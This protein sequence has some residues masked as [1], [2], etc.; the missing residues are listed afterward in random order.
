ML[1]AIDTATEVA[2]LALAKDGQILAEMTW[3]TRQNHTVQ[4]LPNLENL[5]KLTGTTP[6][7]LTAVIVGLG[8]GSFNGLRVGV[9]AAKGLAF[10]LNIPI[11]GINSLEVSA[12]PYAATGLPVC[13]VIN[14]GRSEVATA[15]YQSVHG[16]WQRTAPDQIITLEQLCAQITQPTVFCGDFVPQVATQLQA[17]LGKKAVIASPLTDLRRAAFLA[18]L[19]LI[20]LNTGD[21]DNL[22]T[23]QP[24]YI[25]RPPI[26][27]AKKL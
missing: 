24:I 22:N 14:A 5:F 18:E 4:L 7:D 3:R 2:A 21:T 25:R 10:S 1:V 16:Q 13:P 11:V 8:P 19:G 15:F 27:Q 20:R 23:L 6:H 12:Y 26:T 17:S 9:G